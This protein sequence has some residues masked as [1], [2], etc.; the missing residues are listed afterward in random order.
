MLQRRTPLRAKRPIGRRTRLRPVNQRRR[1]ERQAAAFGEQAERCRCAPCLVCK[2]IPSDP[3][4]EPTRA[5][6][7]LDP[8]TVPLCRACH[9]RRHRIGKAAFERRH[10]VD[11]LAEAHRMRTT[12][13]PDTPY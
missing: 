13:T 9:E 10:D 4:H 2:A 12:E 3:H 8:D 7:G 5:R 11:L 1:A 6:G